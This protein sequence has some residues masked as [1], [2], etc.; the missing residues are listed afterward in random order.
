VP[1]ACRNSAS[2]VAAVLACLTMVF[3][4]RSDANSSASGRSRTR[5]ASWIS[6]S[7]LQS[8]PGH[9]LHELL[10][11]SDALGPVARSA[12]AVDPLQVLLHGVPLLGRQ[13]GAALEVEHPARL[14]R[15][16]IPRSSTGWPL[17][18]LHAPSD[19]IWHCMGTTSTRRGLP[20]PAGEPLPELLDVDGVAH[21]LGVSDRYVRRLVAERRIPFIKWGRYLRFDP[22]EVSAWIDEARVAAF[23]PRTSRSRRAG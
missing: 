8:D 11:R 20:A 5:C 10:G 13:H 16:T 23:N 18:A 3:V 19:H 9:R 17:G 21:V 1:T 2:W 7:D 4:G 12:G 14:P 22:T 6:A 15:R